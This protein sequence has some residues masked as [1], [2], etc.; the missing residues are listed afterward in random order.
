MKTAKSFSRSSREEALVSKY[1]QSKLKRMS[2]ELL[3]L[4]SHFVAESRLHSSTAA[5][6]N[7]VLL[8]Y[9]SETETH[10][11]FFKY[12]FIWMFKACKVGDGFAVWYKQFIC[13]WETK[14]FRKSLIMS[15]YKKLIYYQPTEGIYF[16]TSVLHLFNSH[17]NKCSCQFPLGFHSLLKNI[18][19]VMNKVVYTLDLFASVWIWLRLF[20]VPPA[21]LVWF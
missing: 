11:K 8:G 5:A 6:N 12:Y 7:M 16:P 18:P 4:L 21:T 17:W 9:N 3:P 10:A 14:D 13:L 20:L 15:S 1:V 19:I 2:S